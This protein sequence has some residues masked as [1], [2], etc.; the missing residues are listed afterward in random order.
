MKHKLKYII[1]FIAIFIIFITINSFL[2]W[3]K[4]EKNSPIIPFYKGSELQTNNNIAVF[5]IISETNINI[6][7]N[8][9][10]EWKTENYKNIINKDII[11]KWFFINSSWEFLT[12]KHIFSNKN[13]KFYIEINNHK[14]NFKII[15][16]DEKKDIILWQIKNYKNKSFL[17][18]NRAKNDY[19]I[20]EALKIF[21]Y[22][23]NKK[24][25]WKITWISK[26]IEKLN[27]KNLIKTNI[28]LYSWDSWSPLLNEKNIVIWIF[29]AIKIWENISYWEK[30]E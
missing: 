27:L 18:I 28:K 23:D 17:K 26:N 4:L 30:I 11:W 2:F 5:N 20:Y 8:I 1:W 14:Y 12:A 10:L 3:K 15:K 21:T 29:V 22:K 24:I 6:D 7:K 25:N 16:K 13:S 19:L 9:D